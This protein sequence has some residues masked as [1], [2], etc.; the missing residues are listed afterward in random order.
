MTTADSPAAELVPVGGTSL[1]LYDQGSGPVILLL[2]GAGGLKAGAPFL[3]SLSAKARV[4]APSHPGFG[5]SPLPDWISTID[6]LAYLYL[7]LLEQLD[8]RDVTLVG[9]SMGGWTAAEIAVKSSERLAR[10]VLAD[11]VG[12]KPSGREVRDI[13]DI[14]AL[15]DAELAKLTQ[16]DPSNAPNYATMS[17]ED[18]AVVARN[19]EAAALY[20]WEPYMHNPQLLRRLH[21]I[22]KPTLFIR[23]ASDGL[24]SAEYVRA[25]SAAIAGSRIVTI[26]RA[27]HAPANEQPERFVEA[28]LGFMGD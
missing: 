4:V 22:K 1:E 8:L 9:M 20:L 18:L 24:V 26:E 25:Y 3:R 7:D 2:H 12:I 28:V 17:D 27:G 14:W 15:D 13:P 21:R 23:G 19:R 11:P 6:D 16:H 10:I 5:K